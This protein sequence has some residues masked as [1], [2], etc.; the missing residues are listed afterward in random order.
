MV[1]ERCVNLIRQ[2]VKQMN[3]C[4]TNVSLGRVTFC[5]ELSRDDQV[6]LVTFLMENGFE[7]MSNRNTKLIQQ[8]KQLVRQHLISDH[9][10]RFSSL[11]AEELHMNYDSI[12]EIFSAN[13]GLTLE[14]Y[15]I[16]ERLEK[17]KELLVYS[18]KTLTEIAHILG[19]SSI[20]HLSRQFKEMEGI[21]P[22][23]YRQIRSHKQ[24][25]SKRHPEIL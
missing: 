24:K 8:I 18:D 6:K 22:S 25:V 13:E 11:L 12:S 10:I 15:I 2:H 9:K 21:P 23:Y 5:R 16:G 17:V 4:I 19:Y 14:K 20:N 7:T 3:L 1:C